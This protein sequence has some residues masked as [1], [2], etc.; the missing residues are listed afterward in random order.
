M[1]ELAF[2][3]NI[4]FG[5][6][7]ILYIDAILRRRPCMHRNLPLLPSSPFEPVDLQVF[8]TFASFLAQFLASL[9]P[10]SP[11]PEGDELGN[12]SGWSDRDTTPRTPAAPLPV[13]TLYPP[14]KVLVP[15]PSPR[16]KIGVNHATPPHP[17]EPAFYRWLPTA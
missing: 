3:I 13:H 5:S 15:P 9:P 1:N 11:P 12:W 16:R 8:S 17:L 10:P 4:C 7:E 2:G 6:E 14:R